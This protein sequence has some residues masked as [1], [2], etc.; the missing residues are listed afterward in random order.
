MHPTTKAYYAQLKKELVKQGYKD[1]LMVISGKR[2]KWWNSILTNFGAAK[3]SQH[4]K[5]NA[6][7]ILVLDVNDDGKK[8]TK[9]VDIV[10]RILN[11]KI[12]GNKGGIGTYKTE[13]VI[14]NRQMVHIDCRG[15][16]A[17]WHR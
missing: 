16:R 15:Y 4:L 14:W 6:I 2:P 10:Y 3:K 17:R 13:K 7:D 12:I 1:R 9:D 11:Q 8:D 5:G